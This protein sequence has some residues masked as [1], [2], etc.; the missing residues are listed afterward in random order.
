MD[1]IWAHSDIKS[2][3]NKNWNCICAIEDSFKWTLSEILAQNTHTINRY[4][5]TVLSVSIGWKK[6]EIQFTDESI[7]QW[8]EMIKYDD[9]T[10]G[11]IVLALFLALKKDKWKI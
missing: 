11:S 4:T 8:I 5:I 2:L 3:H 9:H 6:D 7:T 1:I 10:I